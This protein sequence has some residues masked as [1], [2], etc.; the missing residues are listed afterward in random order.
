MGPCT[1]TYGDVSV[2]PTTNTPYPIRGM[3]FFQDRANNLPNGQANF[4]G[5]GGLLL[6]GSLYFHN[7][8]N[9]PACS[10]Y[11]TDYNAILQFQG[12]PGSDTRVVGNITVDSL[13]LSGNGSIDMVLDPN[14]VRTVLKA[15][16][17]R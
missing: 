17:V 1:G 11:N 13:N 15:T 14:R 6:A 10:P 4:Q 2:D 12:N 3:L 7:C 5:G 8:P 9:S 16:L